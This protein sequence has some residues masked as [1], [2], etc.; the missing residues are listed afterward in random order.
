MSERE[1]EAAG[2]LVVL[3]E[4]VSQILSE[5]NCWWIKSSDDAHLVIPFRWS[6]VPPYPV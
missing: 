1:Q 3:N 2:Q 6:L 4:S 5:G